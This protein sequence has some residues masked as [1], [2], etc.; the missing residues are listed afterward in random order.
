MR[1]ERGL[2]GLG[3]AFGFGMFGLGSVM[4]QQAPGYGYG[5]PPAGYGMGYTY[6]KLKDYGEAAVSFRRF[7]MARTGDDRQRADALMRLG[8]CAF[9]ARDN[10]AALRWYEQAAALHSPDRDYARYQKGVVQG[11]LRDNPGK[12][13]TLTALLNDQPGSRFAADARYQLAETY[14]N[15]EKDSEALSHYNMLIEQHPNIRRS[16]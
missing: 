10:D 2:F 5:E 1:I 11:L 9:V 4:A 7:I 14:I 8:D 12:I 13:A 3:L 6:F 15:Q 16:A